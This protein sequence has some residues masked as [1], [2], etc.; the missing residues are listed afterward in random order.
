MLLL[1]SPAKSLNYDDPV[2]Q[3]VNHSLPRFRAHAAALVNLLKKKSLA[4]VSALMGLSESLAILNVARYDAWQ[5]RFTAKNSKPAI[6]AFNGDVYDGLQVDLLSAEDLAWAQ[7]HVAILSGLY[8]ALSPLDRI[9]PY[10]LEMGTRLANAKGA[11]LYHFWKDVIGSHLAKQARSI[12][13]KAVVNLAS[14]EY[15]RAVDTSVLPVPV[16]QCVFE[17]WKD[18]RYKVISFFAKRAR[19]MMARFAIQSKFSQAEDLKSFTEG[20]YLFDPTCSDS[21]RW[22]FRRRV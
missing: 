17:D 8:G 7:S 3:E 1:L 15:F 21:Q 4:E 13:A 10:R 16:V 11:D 9:Q 19:G 18:G 14:Q 2:P 5:N 6:Y 22:V 12:R 20:G